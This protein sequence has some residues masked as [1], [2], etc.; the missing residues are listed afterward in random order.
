MRFVPNITTDVIANIQQSNQSVAT[1]LQQVSTGQRV[2]VPSDDP[3]AA[4]A[5]LQLQAQSANIDQYTSN[6]ESVLSQAQSADGVI[7]SVVSLLNQA[8]TMG[9]EGANEVNNPSNRASIATDVQGILSS[10]VGLANTNYQGVSLFGGSATG[11]AFTADASSPTGYTYNGN[12]AINQVQVGSSVTVQANIPGNTVFDSPSGSVLGA[13]SGLA[14]ALNT[15]TSAQI[16][17]ATQAVTTALDYVSQQH[18]VYNSTVSQL[19]NQESFLAQDKVSISS[20]ENALVG[21]DMAT[22]EETLSQAEISNTATLTASAK[23]LQN[24]LLNYLPN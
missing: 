21:V 11:Q 5:D 7:S 4:A 16:A 17:T 23:V 24:S 12:N 2:N 15:G 1:A 18:T 19:T 8:V 6:A 22:A 14:T 20:N 13:L 10:V 3:A 9:T